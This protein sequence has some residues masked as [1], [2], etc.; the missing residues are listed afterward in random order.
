[1]IQGFILAGLANH[2]CPSLQNSIMQQEVREIWISLRCNKCVNL[3]VTGVIRFRAELAVDDGKYSAMFV[4]FERRWQ[5][6]PSWPSKK[7]LSLRLRRYQTVDMRSYQAALESLLGR[8]FFSNSC[9]TF[10]TVSSLYDQLSLKIS[11]LTIKLW[12][13]PTNCFHSVKGKVDC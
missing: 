10:F 13:P 1:M 3:H 2:Y 7:L 8:S 11:S 9:H 12:R 5:S 6:W 4:V